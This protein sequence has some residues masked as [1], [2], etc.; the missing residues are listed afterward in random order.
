MIK[1]VCTCVYPGPAL[2]QGIL[3]VAGNLMEL[4]RG[5]SL[6]FRKFMP[7]LQYEVQILQLRKRDAFFL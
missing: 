7:R 2:H 5:F 6:V 4:V 3:T 1:P